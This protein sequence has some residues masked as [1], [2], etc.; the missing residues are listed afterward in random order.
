M[1]SAKAERGDTKSW[2]HEDIAIVECLLS[3]HVVMATYRDAVRRKVM[4]ASVA[5]KEAKAIRASYDANIA[6]LLQQGDDE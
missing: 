5:N 6:N 1:F 3:K 2:P 4:T